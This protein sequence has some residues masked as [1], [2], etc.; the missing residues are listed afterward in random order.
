[1]WNIERIF[2]TPDHQYKG[3]YGGPP[4]DSPMEE[5][6]AITCLA[7]RGIE[8][9][10]YLDFKPDY[11]GQITFF[12]MEVYESLLRNLGLAPDDNPPSGVRRNVFTRGV[13]LVEFIGKRFQI[14]GIDFE[15]TEE[16]RPCVWM[17]HAFSEGANDFLK[18]QGGLR[19]KILTNG[20]LRKDPA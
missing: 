11:K 13:N 19:A 5:R 15:G 20:T 18:G 8:G 4:G 3:F 1:M 17:D 14:Q 6:D 12:S 10:R 2:I 16:C 7:G 9:D